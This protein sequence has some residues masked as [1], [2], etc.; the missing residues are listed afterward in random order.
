MFL[1]C[2]EVKFQMKTRFFCISLVLLLLILNSCNYKINSAEDFIAELHNRYYGV[3]FKELSF[4][5]TTKFY[6]NQEIVKSEK[7]IEEYKFPGSLLIKI[8]FLTGGDGY[9]YRNDSVYKFID[10]NIVEAK[11]QIHDFLFLSKDIYNTPVEEIYEK[12]NLMNY[13]VSKFYSTVYNNRNAYVIGSEMG[14]YKSNQIWYDAEHLFL[15]RI[16]RTSERGL[17]EVIFDDYIEIP[18]QGWV[19]QE[20]TFKLDGEIYMIEKYYDIKIPEHSDTKFNSSDFSPYDLK[21]ISKQLDVLKN[22]VIISSC[23]YLML[24]ILNEM[25]P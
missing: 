14:D 3:W 13:D 2:K 19:E 4:S 18:G 10:G 9:L 7:W 15:L 11:S 22:D 25:V 21:I 17:Q 24:W 5:Q 16:I 12:L 6:D 23:R 1:D 20:L 8:N